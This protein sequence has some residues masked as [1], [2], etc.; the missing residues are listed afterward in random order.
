MAEMSFINIL[1]F[2]V[3]KFILI[4]EGKINTS[5]LWWGFKWVQNGIC[6]AIF[7][8]MMIFSLLVD[9]KLFLTFFICF[10]KWQNYDNLIIIT[11]LLHTTKM[12][13][14]ALLDN[15]DVAVAFVLDEEPFYIFICFLKWQNSWNFIIIIYFGI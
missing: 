8:Q 14:F 5:Y 15:N 11:L 9:A 13:R 3:W 6:L 2:K 10:V 1:I 12:R 4:C 7:N